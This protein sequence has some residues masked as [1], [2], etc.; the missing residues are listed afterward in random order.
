VKERKRGK[1]GKKRWGKIERAV[2]EPMKYLVKMFG[3]FSFLIL[4]L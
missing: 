3:A 4:N 1:E 2:L